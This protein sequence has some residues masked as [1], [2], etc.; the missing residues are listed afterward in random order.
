[1]AEFTLHLQLGDADLLTPEDVARELAALSEQI[2]ST[3]G[4]D[5][6]IIS[7]LGNRVGSFHMELPEPPAEFIKAC[8]IDAGRWVKVG[9]ES[10]FQRLEQ[11]PEPMPG[12]RVELI[13]EP[14]SEGFLVDAA[15]QLP[16]RIDD[17]A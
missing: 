13:L 7:S 6:T 16:V 4:Q 8:E 12:G 9:D 11:D 3:T 1:M 5:G 15:E 14:Y 2:D 10:E 17:G